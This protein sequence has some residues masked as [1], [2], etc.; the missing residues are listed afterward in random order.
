MKAIR[1]ASESHRG[2]VLPPYLWFR[3]VYDYLVAYNKHDVDTGKLLES[4]TPLYFAR[5]AS[6]VQ[7]AADDSDER[8]EGR[9][10]AMVDA[11]LELKP[12]LIRRWREQ[13]VPDREIAV[14]HVL[15]TQVEESVH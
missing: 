10:N 14:Q 11:A 8:A 9:I 13:G 3:I 15:Q 4:L 7:E 6:Y 5:T 2:L 1:E 12:Y